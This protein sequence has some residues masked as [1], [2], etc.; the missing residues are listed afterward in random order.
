MKEE[1]DWTPKS[2]ES[3]VS[4]YCKKHE[5]S[6]KRTQKRPPKRNREEYQTEIEVFREKIEEL[7]TAR[8]G[9]V[10]HM[11]E[12]GLYDDPVAP[13]SYVP[14]GQEAM[15]NTVNNYARDTII[16]VVCENGEKLPL[17]Y[18]RHERKRYGTRVNILTGERYRVLLDKGISGLNNKI[19]MD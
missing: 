15:A 7:R 8:Q 11:D 19:M 14:V 9:R 13:R 10:W 17:Y 3:W 4:R 16:T 2:G 5:L 12:A 18:V 1:F 6:S